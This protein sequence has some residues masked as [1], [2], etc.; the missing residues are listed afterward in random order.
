MVEAD[1]IA[2]FS[3]WLDGRATPEDEALLRDRF[4]ALSAEDQDELLHQDWEHFIP[5]TNPYFTEAQLEFMLANIFNRQDQA[6]PGKIH[7]LVRRPWWRVAAAAAVTGLLLLSGY[8]IYKYNSR[9]EA[10]KTEIKAL[11][12]DVLPG[13]NKATL[14]LGNGSTIVLDSAGIGT[15]A[16]QGSATVRKSGSGRLA[17]NVIPQTPAEMMYNTVTTPR[18]G[19][20]Q[21]TLSDGTRVW[22]NAAS[23]IRFPVLFQGKERSVEVTGEVY[24]EVAHN[25]KQPFKV[26]AGEQIVEDI[27]T[28]FNINAYPDEGAIRTTLIEGS[29]KVSEGKDATVLKPG[30]QTIAGLQQ[31]RVQHS[32]DIDQVMAW[33]N[34][35]FSFDHADL[36]TVMRQLARWYDVDVRYEG[37]IP[38]KAF[39]GKIGRT[40]TLSQALDVL[41]MTSRVHYTIAGKQL[42]IRP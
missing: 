19:Q 15:I 1:L 13:G 24:F 29:V 39:N 28:A 30:E 21:L 40:L 37:Q 9:K 6:R 33:K 4:E 35:L 11:A 17:Y 25:D 2:L 27:G 41:T 10:A 42:T 23:S 8:Y 26:K 36:Q 18:G 3:R 31:F 12:Q 7:P 20:Y 5:A 22:L 38:A 16:Q 14:T 34:G 32:V